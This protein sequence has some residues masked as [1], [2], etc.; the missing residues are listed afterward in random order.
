LA[1]KS[2]TSEPK[3]YPLSNKKQSQRKSI[4][5]AC[6]VLKSEDEMPTP[7]HEGVYQKFPKEVLQNHIPQYNVVPY[8][9]GVNPK[10]LS[11]AQISQKRQKNILPKFFMNP[12]Q[13]LDYMVLQDI[14]ANSIGGRIIDRKEELKFGNGIKPVLKLRNPKSAGDEEKQQKLIDENQDIIDKLLMIDDA[15][16]DPDDDLD[17]DLDA[18]IN[19]K[20][21]ALSKN[22]SVYGRCMIVKEFTKPL[23]LADGTVTKGIPNIL[24]VIH[25]RDIGIVQINQESWKL[26]SVNIR[27]TSQNIE[28]KQMIYIENGSNN[29]VYNALHYGFSDM[30]SMI[31]ASRALRQ[32]IEVDF[33]TITKHVWAGIGFMFINPQGTTDAQKQTELDNI[34]STARVGRLNNIMIDP[35]RVRVDFQ[36]FNPKINELVSLADFLIRYNIAQTGMPQALFAQEQ[37]SNRST[38]VQK[39]R[40]FMDGGLKNIQKEFTNQF[41]R[42][43]YMPNFAALYGKDSKEF[44]TFKIDAEFEPLKIEA[45]DDSVEAV[46]KLN[47]EFPLTIKAAGELLGIDNFESKIDPDMERPDPNRQG[48]SFMDKNGEE[49]KMTR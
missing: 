25:P 9:R 21:Q 19:T 32:M 5:I 14:Y 28:P 31:G 45:F 2:K 6:G 7:Y 48:F 10:P 44:K 26:E 4:H 39:I 46:I 42:Q 12:Y 18:N 43:W 27:F 33:P 3:L 34:N 49:V 40:L 16:S 20:F 23:V 29:P 22:A 24:K 30:Q 1:K 11:A 17:S 36:D 47:K 38:L 35:E 15:I 8:S 13:D 41:S 37:D